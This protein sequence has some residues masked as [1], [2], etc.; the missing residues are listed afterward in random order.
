M[1]EIENELREIARICTRV[2]GQGTGRAGFA[3]FLEAGG[4]WHYVSN[5]ERAD[6][7]K[8]MEE[9]LG[10]LTKGSSR[11][12]SSFQVDSRLELER[13]CARLGKAIAS[14]ARVAVFMFDFGEGGNLAFFTNIPDLQRGIRRWI[15][16]ER[17]RS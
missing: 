15:D 13:R 12:Q 3:L 7:V 2:A 16:T 1:T 8:T 4:A 6:V 10:C 9:W 14:A 17:G 11:P 5:A